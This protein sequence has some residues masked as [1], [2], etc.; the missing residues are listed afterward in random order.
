MAKVFIGKVE[1][2]WLGYSSDIVQQNRVLSLNLSLTFSLDHYQGQYSRGLRRTRA[3]KAASD[4]SEMC[5]SSAP[6]FTW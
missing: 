6:I 5:A 2:L 3:G 4:V 1:G